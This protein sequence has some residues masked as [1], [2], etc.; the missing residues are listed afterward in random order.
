[1]RKRRGTHE[2]WVLTPRK[3]GGPRGRTGQLRRT[4]G[5]VLAQPADVS[6]TAAQGF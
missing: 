3:K 2:T 6:P 1:M 4:I 5:F